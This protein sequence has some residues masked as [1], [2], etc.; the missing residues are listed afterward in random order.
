MD[1]KDYRDQLD[2]LDAQLVELFCRRMEICGDVAR[3]KK[4]NGK[5]IFDRTRER[6]KL[7]TVGELSKEEFEP[8]VRCMFRSLFGYSRSY[9][10]KLLDPPSALAEEI[11]AARLGTPELFP[12]EAAVACQ[13]VEGAYSSL[14]CEKLF[15]DP[16]IKFYPTFE[17]VFAAVDNGECRYGILPIENSTAG[18]VKANYDL[19]VKYQ[20]N[21]VRSTRL[22]V[23]HCLLAKPGV[24]L[25]DI[26][27]IY[28]HEQAIG[29]CSKF[30][31]SLTGVEVK[32]CA[33]TAVAAQMVSKSEDPGIAAI[34]SRSCA[35]LY[36]LSILAETIQDTGANRT[37]FICISKKKEIYPGANR[38]TLILVLKHKPGALFSVLERCNELGV[39][40]V[41]LE[42]RPLPE[43]DF[44]FLFYLDLDIPAA[45]P[46]LYELIALLEAETEELRY[47][48]SYLEVV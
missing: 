34:S 8:Y 3:W 21:I 37:R 33:N 44:E 26:K 27:V 5:P 15:R 10:H 16:E 45:S 18:S 9:Q 12:T 41:K 46:A 4:E 22:L 30:L 13:G 42:S 24:K 14:A 20:C 31:A 25:S 11:N 32:A 47:L 38:T 28:S 7:N 39:N 19:L 48:G 23:S 6:D 36:G 35:E 40:L 43:R 17:D 29:Q 2:V 1:I